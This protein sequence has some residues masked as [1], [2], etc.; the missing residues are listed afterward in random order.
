MATGVPQV[1]IKL[2]LKKGKLE[3]PENSKYYLKCE[4]CG[5]SIRYGRYCPECVKELA[6]GI[7]AVFSEDAGEKP[8]YDD[9][10]TGK[11][12]Y[13]KRQPGK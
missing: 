10:K 11:L 13:M 4:K 1:L 5:C 7:K 6:G 12:H 2:F 9:S 3:I 8:K